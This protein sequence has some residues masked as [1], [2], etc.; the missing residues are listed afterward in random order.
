MKNS[1]KIYNQIIEECIAPF[2]MQ[3]G[4]S[5]KKNYFYYKNKDLIYS[6]DCYLEKMSKKKFHFYIIASVDSISLNNTINKPIHKLPS[7]YDNIY[8]KVIFET[9]NL[10]DESETIRQKII[11]V[12]KKI[13]NKLNEIITTNDLIDICI[14][15]NYLVHHEDI[16]KYCIITKDEKRLKQYLTFVRKRLTEISDRAYEAYLNKIEELRKEL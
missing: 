4:Y 11:L 2:L 3:I 9:D 15:E 16:F 12:L 13:E 14:K 1:H 5:R 10:K 6:Y 7:G 8:S